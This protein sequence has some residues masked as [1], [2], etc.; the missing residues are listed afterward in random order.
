M[1]SIFHLVDDILLQAFNYKVSTTSS[2]L[3]RVLNR[4]SQEIDPNFINFPY[5]TLCHDTLNIRL[6]APVSYMGSGSC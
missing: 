4:V 2:V 1:A 3:D 5:L 6:S